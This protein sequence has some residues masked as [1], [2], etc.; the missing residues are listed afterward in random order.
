MI[1]VKSEAVD[2]LGRRDYEELTLT[3]LSIEPLRLAEA[4]RGQA[5]IMA[6]E[7]IPLN[8]TGLQQMLG[9]LANLDAPAAPAVALG[10]VVRETV[11][12]L[13]GSE[14]SAD[15]PLMEAGLDSLGA[16]EFQS[17]LSQRLGGD[18]TLSDT[19][20]FDFP[21]LRQIEAHVTTLLPATSAAAPAA[22]VGG[23][24]AALLQLLASQCV[25]A[26]F[27]PVSY[28]QHTSGTACRSLCGTSMVLSGGVAAGHDLWQLSVDAHDLVVEVPVARWTAREAA[29]I[30]TGDVLGRTR[31]GGFKLEQSF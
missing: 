1:L 24:P 18:I 13:M 3:A 25:D 12:E 19:L 31:H 16:T 20:I 30:D 26:T 28:A 14:V 9:L 17:R 27:P 29:S 2:A 23:L 5:K 11:R 21:T 8:A 4:G 6:A 22:A 15:V 10:A 7:A